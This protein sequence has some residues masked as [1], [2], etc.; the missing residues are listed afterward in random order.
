MR[1]LRKI[2]IALAALSL[3]T[4]LASATAS[5]AATDPS[6]A[7]DQFFALLNATRNTLGHGELQRDTGLDA[8]ALDWANHM[9]DVYDT[10]RTIRSK[11]LPSSNCDA[12]SALCH[13]PSLGASGAAIEPGWRAIGENVG[14]G[15]AVEGLHDAFVKSP[16]HFAN[17]IGNY[18]RVGIGVVVRNERIWVTFNFLLGPPL[19]NP[20]TPTEGAKSKAVTGGT[21]VPVTPLGGK[22]YYKPVDPTR[23]VDTRNGT[24]GAGPVASNSTFTISLAGAPGRPTGALGAALNITATGSSADGYLTVFPCGAP[25]PVASNVNFSAGQSVPNL[26]AAPFG[27]NNTVC[28]FTSARTHLLVDIAGWFGTNESDNSID[29]IAPSRILDSRATGVKSRYFA[30]SLGS[31]APADA[32]AA[33][34]NITATQPQGDGYVTA[35]P[36]GSD[37]PDSS[38]V[39]FRAGESVPNL[40]VVRIGTA[41]SICFFS[42][43]PTH[44]IVDSDGWFGTGGGA[45][46]PV[47][48]NRVLDTRNGIGGW[49]GRLGKGQVVDVA[50]GSLPGMDRTATGAILNVTAANG[51]TDGYITV[52]PCGG[53]TPTAS[54]LNFSSGRTVANLVAVDVPADGH[55]CFYAN[56]RVDVVADLA[57]FV[58]AS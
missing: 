37:V 34:I 54:N 46:R 42:S 16:G 1:F 55:V 41:R 17:I 28:V 7:G 15:G 57:A 40:A 56:E 45:L 11:D 18:N 5:H 6:V 3:T 12:V 36:C 44:L 32:T 24:G 8:L 30:V 49:S 33:T 9:A 58:S 21:S 27:A 31:I 48:P 43:V 13:R 53:A 2:V 20:T 19:A 52:Y 14:T 47:I 26:V 23:V 39:N 4:V 22:A 38:S 50:V 25:M 10:T 51:E 35:Y 29:T